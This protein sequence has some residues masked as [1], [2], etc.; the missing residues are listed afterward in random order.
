MKS[1]RAFTLIE[2][3]VI[4]SIIGILAGTVLVALSSSKGRGN[5]AGVKADLATIQV[6][7]TLYY[8]IGNTYG[9]TNT[10]ATASC[11]A[12]GTVF[13]DTTTTIDDIVGKAVAS[14]NKDIA[15]GSTLICQ[16]TS[17]AFL[18]AGQITNGHYWC[19]DS[20]G[21]AVEET[22]APANTLTACP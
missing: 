9:A 12:S 13:N 1:S 22:S 19:V 7:A 11:S 20:I 18:V 16:N 6:Q 21:S 10:G 15:S 5:D 17:S 2:L 4:V 3:L 14:A 8:G